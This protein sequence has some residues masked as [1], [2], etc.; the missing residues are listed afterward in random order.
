MQSELKALLAKI[1]DTVFAS[2]DDEVE[3]LF[4]E[5]IDRFEKVEFLTALF[6][7][8]SSGT[9]NNTLLHCSFVWKTLTFNEYLELLRNL[10][11]TYEAMYDFITFSGQ[12]LAIDVKRVIESDERMDDVAVNY[13]CEHFPERTPGPS[14]HIVELFMEEWDVN[15]QELWRRLAA[16][17]APMK[18]VDQIQ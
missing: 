7:T 10:S 2:D 5:E 9:L 14:Q 18:P 4:S 15:H 17:G 12:Y 1:V 6:S 8:Y 13:V 11:G 3:S 16:E